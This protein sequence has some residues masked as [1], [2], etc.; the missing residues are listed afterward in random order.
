MKCLP[1]A[2][3]TQVSPA[4]TMCVQAWRAK[5]SIPSQAIIIGQ[6]D[7]AHGDFQLAVQAIDART[8][9]VCKI[10]DFRRFLILALQ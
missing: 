8:F 4:A 1:Q 7:K 3:A 10:S 9:K 5:M 6:P 2:I